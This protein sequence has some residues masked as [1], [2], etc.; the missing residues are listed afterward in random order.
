MAVREDEIA[1]SACGIDATHHKVV[2]FVIGSFFA[3]IAGALFSLHERSITP[4]YFGLQKSIEIVVMV[5][6]GGLGSISGAIVTAAVLTLLPE[7]LRGFSEWRMILYSLLLIIMM[8]VRPQGLLGSREI[9]P[10]GRRRGGRRGPAAPPS[11]TRE[12]VSAAP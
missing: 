3:G 9:W 1:A 11:P 10:F 4:S 5:T 7:L 8:L 2:A 12:P 6:L